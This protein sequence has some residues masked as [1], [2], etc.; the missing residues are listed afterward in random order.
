M[1]ATNTTPPY[2][3]AAAEP[4]ELFS[5]RAVLRQ[6]SAALDGTARVFLAWLPTPCVSFELHGD[7]DMIDLD[8]ETHLELPDLDVSAPVMLTRSNS[9]G[10]VRGHLQ[11]RTSFGTPDGL[12][13]ITFML[14]NTQRMVGG[15]SITDGQKHWRGRVVLESQPWRVTVE[16]R[17]DYDQAVEPVKGSG[18]YV[19]THVCQL[20]R[21]DGHPFSVADADHVVFALHHF[22]SFARGLWTPPLLLV[23]DR[24][25]EIVWREWFARTSSGWRGHTSWFSDHH[26]ET[27]AAAF[28]TFMQRWSDP[29]WRDELQSAITWLTEAM[30]QPFLDISIALSQVA[31]ELLGWTIL[32]EERK[33]LSR[34]AYKNNSAEQNLQQLLEWAGI[35]SEIPSE[36]HNL[37]ELAAASSWPSGPKALAGFRNMLVHP[38]D[39]TRKIFEIPLAAK[40]ELQ[41][42]A[43]WYVELILL[44]FIGYRGEYVNRH[45][46]THV[47]QVEPVPWA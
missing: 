35:P 17:S 41:Q 25:G 45:H 46:A 42:L 20:A 10:E 47:G 21:A 14:A 23:G 32:V 28:P 6:E 19:L 12:S 38:R 8:P 37:G 36:L 33:L 39:Q 13:S 5:G 4:V 3:F 7:G 24:D 11:G 26:P 27:L 29:R 22:L 30:Q 34:T 16:P 43:F 18:G 31:L 15:E 44:R 1:D 2:P 9:N 40:R